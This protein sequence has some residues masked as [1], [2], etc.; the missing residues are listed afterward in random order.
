MFRHDHIH[1]L[2]ADP[3]GAIE[4]YK[5]Y[6]DTLSKAEAH[7]RTGLEAYLDALGRQR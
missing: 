4:W 7:R 6:L 3:A 5:Q 1:H 2:A